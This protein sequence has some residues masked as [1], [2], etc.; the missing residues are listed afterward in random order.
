MLEL[1]LK[2]SISNWVNKTGKSQ[3]KQQLYLEGTLLHAAVL[4]MNITT[5]D[6]STYNVATNRTLVR[7]YFLGLLFSN[8]KVLNGSELQRILKKSHWGFI[9][10]M[11]IKSSSWR[12]CPFAIRAGHKWG[13][14][15]NDNTNCQR[16]PLKILTITDS[17]WV[18]SEV[19]SFSKI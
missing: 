14:A 10:L 16:V 3:N 5:R 2:F 15:F 17:C 13:D 9:C 6:I 18:L 11:L 12:C 7:Y 1:W 4:N 8:M 19:D